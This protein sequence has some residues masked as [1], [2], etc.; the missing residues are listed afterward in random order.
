[1]A[2]LARRPGPAWERIHGSPVVVSGSDGR[3]NLVMQYGVHP[4]AH[5]GEGVFIRRQENPNDST[6][7]D[8]LFLDLRPEPIVPQH[9]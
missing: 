5:I 3:L 9:P 7:G 6:W 8:A 1:M 4:G 2:A